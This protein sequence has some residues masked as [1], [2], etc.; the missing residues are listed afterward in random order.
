MPCCFSHYAG[1]YVN[2]NIPEEGAG[3]HRYAMTTDT[4]DKKTYIFVD[5][6]NFYLS[7]RTAFGLRYPNFDVKSVANII[8]ERATGRPAD[9]VTFYTGMP[10][11]KFSPTWHGF[12]TNKLRAMEEDGIDTFTRPLRYTYETDPQAATGFKILSTRE[13]GIDLRIAL[14][15]MEA[16]RRPDCGD[17]I[18]VSRDQDFQEVIEKIEIMRAFEN[19]EIGLWSS[20]PDGG[21]GPSHLRG[22]DGTKEVVVTRDD[23]AKC[24]DNHDYRGTYTPRQQASESMSPS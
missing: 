4:Q 11:H 15:A 20:Y 21:N 14:D 12:W 2:E 19:R 24:I 23:Y 17:I 5:G 10:V 7:A 1:H 6:Q 18:I 22:I 3:R 13:K 8:S 9:H 16:A